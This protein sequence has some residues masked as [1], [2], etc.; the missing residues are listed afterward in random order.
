MNDMDSIVSKSYSSRKRDS[1]AL[2]TTLVDICEYFD[3]VSH[4]L[5]D[6]QACALG[7]L[8]QRNDCSEV[9]GG[10][11]YYHRDAA[12]GYTVNINKPPDMELLRG[13]VCK[14]VQAGFGPN[15]FN[16]DEFERGV[17]SFSKAVGITRHLEI[18]YDCSMNDY[19]DFF[20]IR[21]NGNRVDNDDYY[22]T[23][24]PIIHGGSRFAIFR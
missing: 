8:I 11:Y 22:D 15:G 5:Q 17:I 7:D 19:K 1:M 2:L 9:L 18:F 16:F 6:S 4:L 23:N 12:T 21:I 20:Q 13:E 24:T 3:E 14:H 10:I